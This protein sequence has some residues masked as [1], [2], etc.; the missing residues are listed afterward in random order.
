MRAE[1]GHK[2]ISS[3]LLSLLLSVEREARARGDVFLELLRQADPALLHWP[4]N[5]RRADRQ[6]TVSPHP[7]N[8]ARRGTAHRSS[9]S[10]SAV[11]TWRQ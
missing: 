2:K 5:G 10:N 9:E 6:K 4:V 1:A 11:V 8:P 7:S 3:V